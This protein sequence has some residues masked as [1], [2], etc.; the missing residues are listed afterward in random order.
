MVNMGLDVEEEDVVCTAYLAADYLK[1]K[2]FNKKVHVF[3]GP[4]IFDEVVFCFAHLTLISSH[5]CV[6]LLFSWKR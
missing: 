4:G 5:L 6:L 3:G 1:Q 2:K